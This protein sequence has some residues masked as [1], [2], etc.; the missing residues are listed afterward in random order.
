MGL[1]TDSLARNVKENFG[2]YCKFVARYKT[3]LKTKVV[4]I[5]L[6]KFKYL[7]GLEPLVQSGLGM[8]IY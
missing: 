1:I 2:S 8:A 6:C 5:R 7:H 3:D 4:I